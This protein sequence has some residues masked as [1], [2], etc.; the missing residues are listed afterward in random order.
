MLG[1]ANYLTKPVTGDALVGTLERCGLPIR[2]GSDVRVLL[3]GEPPADVDG[4]ETRLRGAGCAVERTAETGHG[5]A[6]NA[7]LVLVDLRS[8][9]G[10]GTVGIVGLAEGQQPLPSDWR[11]AFETLARADVMPPDHLV[12]AVQQAVERMRA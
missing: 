11:A 3:V 6:A 10:D 7:D 5:V 8:E 1:A 12:R 9:R 4:L 2:R